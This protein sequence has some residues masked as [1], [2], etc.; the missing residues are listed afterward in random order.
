[1]SAQQPN[2]EHHQSGGKVALVIIG[3]MVGVI[4]LVLLV[5]MLF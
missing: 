4:V 2:V 1:M 5:K 3:F